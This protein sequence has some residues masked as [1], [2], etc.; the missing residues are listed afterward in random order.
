MCTAVL[1]QETV[2]Q[3]APWQVHLH[4]ACPHVCVHVHMCVQVAGEP[5]LQRRHVQALVNQELLLGAVESRHALQ[6]LLSDKLLWCAAAPVDW[7][8]ARAQ[9]CGARRREGEVRVGQAAVRPARE[10]VRLL[11]LLLLIM[12]G[13]RGLVGQPETVLQCCD[14]RQG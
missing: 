3:Q 2:K 11:L 13:H 7:H 1:R 10:A 6:H 12:E 4:V 5:H 14:V 9:H 8:G